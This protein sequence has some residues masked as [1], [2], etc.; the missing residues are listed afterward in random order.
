MHPKEQIQQDL[1]TAM[2]AGD[3]QRREILRLLMAAFKQVEVDR[4]IELSENDAVDILMTEAKK[5]R[6][7][8]EEMDKAGRSDLIGQERYELGVIEEYLP[9]QLSREEIESLAREAIQ[10]SGAT[11]PKDIGQVMKV[12]MPRLKGQADGKLVNTVVRELLG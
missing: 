7:S 9:R 3:T 5:R 8:I 12:L 11:T 1:K 4:R 10:E 2:K 6:E